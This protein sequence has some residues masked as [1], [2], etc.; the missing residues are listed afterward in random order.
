MAMQTVLLFISILSSL[1]ILVTADGK[2]IKYYL[3]IV[4]IY[5]FIWHFSAGVTLIFDPVEN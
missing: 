1:L 5:L 4:F 2:L 3:F